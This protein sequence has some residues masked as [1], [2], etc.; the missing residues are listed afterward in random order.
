MIHHLEAELLQ[1]LREGSSFL[2]DVSMQL[3]QVRRLILCH[4]I[5]HCSHLL[6]CELNGTGDFFMNTMLA[7][8]V[9]QLESLLR[10]YGSEANGERDLLHL[11]ASLKFQ[12]LFP[13]GKAKPALENPRTMIL[14]EELQDRLAAKEGHSSQ[15]RWL[16]SQAQA[17]TSDM[18]EVR[19]F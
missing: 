2:R 14:F 7:A 6:L 15:Q 8:K 11:Y 9:I 17:L 10:R 13:E 3:Q 19:G 4:F 5:K 12:D 18:A 1:I 16:L